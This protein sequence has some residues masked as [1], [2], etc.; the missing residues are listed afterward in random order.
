MDVLCCTASILHLTAIAIDRYWAVTRADYSRRN[1]KK[2]IFG[3]IFIVWFT[4]VCIS[5]PSR[6]T[7]ED[8]DRLVED[9]L[10]DGICI[11]NRNKIYTVFSTAGAFFLPMSF[12]LGIYIKIYISAR[13]R[14]RKKKFTWLKYA[15]SQTNGIANC[16]SIVTS[17]EAATLS[18][19]SSSPV[20]PPANGEVL[21]TTEQVFSVGFEYSHYSDK[22]ARLS[23]P[24]IWVDDE[25]GTELDDA[26]DDLLC[27]ITHSGSSSPRPT[28]GSTIQSPIISQSPLPTSR[29]A[30]NYSHLA[31]SSHSLAPLPSPS[32]PT[33]PPPPLPPP[34]PPTLPSHSPSPPF[35]N[36]RSKSSSPKA[37]LPKAN[38]YVMASHQSNESKCKHASDAG[39]GLAFMSVK[40][41]LLNKQLSVTTLEKVLARR[42]RLEHRR[43]QRAARTLAIITGC[44]L[45]CWIPFSVNALVYPLCGEACAVP[46]DGEKFF[47]WLGY[48]N[49][50][51]NPIIYTIFSP[52]YRKAFAKTLTCRFCRSRR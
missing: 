47:L 34:P 21:N 2:I 48:V 38:G 18:G 27:D 16:E 23:S 14:I 3:M 10:N 44:F 7:I 20:K 25:E 17:T 19:H 31:S 32:P 9:V 6:F 11:V 8:T 28:D 39:I 13:Q 15:S 49:S 29:R 43:E 4:S 46:P 41:R 51:L 50:L 12:L 37:S 52:D 5:L 42:E 30:F 33:P 36:S 35:S 45:L 22:D 26:G 40:R 1:N 24:T